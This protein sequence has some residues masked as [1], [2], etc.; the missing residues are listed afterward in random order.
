M[1]TDC[2]N[3]K[4]ECSM[5]REP[6]VWRGQ[7]QSRGYCSE[8]E[9]IISSSPPRAE[10]MGPTRLLTPRWR[11]VRPARAERVVG[12][13]PVKRLSSEGRDGS[14]EIVKTKIKTCEASESRECGGDRATQAIIVQSQIR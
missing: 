9:M 14:H 1:Q 7:S 8:T 3:T 6:R 10:G 5:R 4:T 11:Y 2:S 12:I 13:E